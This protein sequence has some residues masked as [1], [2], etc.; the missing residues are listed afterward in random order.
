MGYSKQEF[1]PEG[2]SGRVAVLSCS[3]PEAFRHAS[4][5]D[6]LLTKPAQRAGFVMVR[7]RGAIVPSIIDD[8][9]IEMD[10]F[11]FG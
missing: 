8:A 4:A 11:L 3:G 7:P 6:R 10:P 2:I 5:P 9:K 1:S